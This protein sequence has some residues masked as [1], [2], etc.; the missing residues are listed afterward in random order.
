MIGLSRITTD[1]AVMGGKPCIRGLRVTVGTIVGLVA[2]GHPEAEILRLHPLP[3][4]GGHSPAVVGR[5]VACGRDGDLAVGPVKLVVDMNL[6]REWVAVLE[7][8]GCEAVH[9]SGAGQS[10]AR[11]RS[12]R[13]SGR[14]PGSL[15][16]S[17]C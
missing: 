6:S 16:S 12:W 7:R 4:G 2:T 1:P 15:R 11:R 17:H 13:S 10:P 14:P 8:H 3:G 5:R 9:R